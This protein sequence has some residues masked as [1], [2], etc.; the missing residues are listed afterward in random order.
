MEGC[1]SARGS[2]L[3]PTP[4]VLSGQPG[5]LHLP[6][7]GTQRGPV[8]HTPAVA[9]LPHH[10]LLPPGHISQEHLPLQLPPG[11]I[12]GEHMGPI[13]EPDLGRAPCHPYQWGGSR[14]GAEGSQLHS[15]CAGARAGGTVTAPRWPLQ[16]DAQRSGTPP[17]PGGQCCCDIDRFAGAQPRPSSW[18]VMDCGTLKAD[19]GSRVCPS[20]SCDSSN[21]G[22]PKA[23]GAD[24]YC[25]LVW[26]DHSLS[27]AWGS[28][29]PGSQSSTV[30][31]GSGW[32]RRV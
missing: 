15:C 13:H 16:R 2:T 26:L 28:H 14:P 24:L 8:S 18:A 20:V 21:H 17:Q 5:H 4:A 25:P 12:S 1:C 19:G 31:P 30:A 32:E 29:S 6:R 23:Q 3:S 27:W 7:E 9:P 22:S 11:A 10:S